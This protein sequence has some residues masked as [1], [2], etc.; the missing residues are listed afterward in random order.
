MI[1]RRGGI[2]FG[3]LG[4]ERAPY[5]TDPAAAREVLQELME[6]IKSVGIFLN[7]LV[8]YPTQYYATVDVYRSVV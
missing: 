1:R 8:R 4:T 2:Q 3:G 5:I 7:F 6:E